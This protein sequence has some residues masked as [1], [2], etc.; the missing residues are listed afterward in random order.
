MP[1]IR[2][3]GGRIS[4]GNHTWG[5]SGIKAAASDGN[6]IFVVESTG[7]VARYDT[8]GARKQQIGDQ[9]SD[10]VYS[11]GYFIVTFSYGMRRRYDGNGA[12]RGQL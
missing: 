2:L 3:Q 1:D 12:D 11:A 7:A 4:V 10:V 9:A 8:G 5:L 6:A